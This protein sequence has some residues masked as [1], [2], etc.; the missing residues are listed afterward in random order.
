ME[1]LVVRAVLVRN[2]DV[3]DVNDFIHVYTIQSVSIW[4][5]ESY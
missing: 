2:K 1:Q 4:E 3:K 5:I